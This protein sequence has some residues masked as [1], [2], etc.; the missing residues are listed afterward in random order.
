[1]GL[2]Y[3]HENSGVE[4]QKKPFTSESSNNFN[5]SGNLPNPIFSLASGF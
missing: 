1:M 4:V 2:K 5:F 3:L